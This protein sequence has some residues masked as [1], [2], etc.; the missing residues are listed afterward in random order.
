M[1]LLKTQE[2]PVRNASVTR[3]IIITDP[4]P[5]ATAR[6]WCK[7]PSSNT[8]FCSGIPCNHTA[9]ILPPSKPQPVIQLHPDNNT[10]YV[11]Y[12]QPAPFHLG[13]CVKGAYSINCG[14]T[15][16][17]V[18]GAGRRTDLTQYMSAT[19]TPD[20]SQLDA[21]GRQVCVAC[22]VEALSNGAGCFP[23]TYSLTYS[24]TN[25]AGMTATAS[26][27]VIIQRTARVSG[28]VPLIRGVTNST[29][30]NMLV[31][32][33]RNASSKAFNLAVRSILTKMGSAAEGL[34]VADVQ[35]DA[36]DLKQYGPADYTILVNVTIRVPVEHKL[37]ALPVPQ[38]VRLAS[39][40]N[41]HLLS[42]SSSS[43][44]ARHTTQ[45]RLEAELQ[46]L[47]ASSSSRVTYIAQQQVS[48]RLQAMVTSLQALMKV[49]DT[50][51]GC[52]RYSSSGDGLNCSSYGVGRR[53]LQSS[54]NSTGN[55]TSSAAAAS[56]TNNTGATNVTQ[57]SP[58]EVD[59]W[60]ASPWTVKK[61]VLRLLP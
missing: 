49:A 16:W 40:A 30:A 13:P 36:V 32:D 2:T 42:S 59:I 23:G 26:R 46:Q 43:S 28:I 25:D 19:E 45:H 12:G 11:E 33:L 53:L 6:Y 56:M 54:S 21:A 34:S 5:D 35:F 31:T 58:P 3:T 27:T 52:N 20:C 41:R 9:A 18:D 14:A 37:P 47:A 61:E 55:D 50:S 8:S 39:S 10:V 4:C 15:A 17:D 22:G 29:A 60:Q 44:D 1:I 51:V 48:T 7:N 38:S 24:V 57:Q